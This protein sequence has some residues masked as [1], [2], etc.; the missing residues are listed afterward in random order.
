MIDETKEHPSL[1]QRTAQQQPIPQ[2]AVSSTPSKNKCVLLIDDEIHVREA[3]ADILEMENIEVLG[4]AN[5]QMG[6]DLYRAQAD[7]IDLILLDLSMPGLSGHETFIKLRELDMGIKIILS[8]GYSQE[9]VHHQFAGEQ[10]AD[11]LSKPYDIGTLIEKV[12]YHL[13]N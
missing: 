1:E 13:A 12:H 9:E 5:G 3:V 2:T 4:A 10:V 8:S 7:D 6:I 11:F